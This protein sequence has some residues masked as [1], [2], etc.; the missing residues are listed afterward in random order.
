M[1]EKR[2]IPITNMVLLSLENPFIIVDLLQ[3][4]VL[5]D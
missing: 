3:K 1:S 5:C 2:G 4:H